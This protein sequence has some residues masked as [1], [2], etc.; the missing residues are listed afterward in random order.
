MSIFDRNREEIQRRDAPLADRMRPTTLDALVGQDHVVG[1]GR[2]LRRALEADRLSSMILYGPPGAG[3]TTIAEI[4]ARSTEA[5]FEKLNAVMSG[6]ADLRRVIAEAHRELGMSGRK[7]ILFVDEV[8]RFNKSQQDA[9]LPAVEKGTVIFVGATTENPYFEVTP[10]LVSRSRVFELR[11]LGEEDLKAV[12]RRALCDAERGLGE[13]RPRIADDALDHIVRVAS[14][15]ARSALNAVELAVLT[16]EPDEEGIRHVTLEIAAESIQR[17]ALQYD[18]D[19]DAHYDTISAFIKSMRGSDPDATLYWLARMIYAG[20]DPSFIS[21]RLVIHAAEDVGLA[22]PNALV[23]AEAAAR[24][25]DRVGLPEGRIILAEAALYIALA[26]K[27]NSALGI[28]AALREVEAG[29]AGGVP[30]HLRDASYRSAG[31]LGRGAGYRY[32]HDD[33]EGWVEQQYLP[34]GAARGAYFRPGPRG[35]EDERM[36]WLRDLRGENGEK[37]E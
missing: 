8:H 19:G 17:R 32:P 26:P 4:I 10:P 7:T 13:Y 2:L 31:K 16:T 15:D 24:A 37:T 14:G 23:V 25:V 33:P 9:L 27:S 3:K 1:E 22:D 11:A 28:D 35:F 30:A 6:V 12:I 29:R 36:R 21:R 18:R 20:E 5:R 34:E